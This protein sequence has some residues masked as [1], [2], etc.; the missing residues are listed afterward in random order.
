MPVDS[1]D[2]V[3]RAPGAT[4]GPL[5]V[6][7]LVASVVVHESVAAVDQPML[8]SAAAP[9]HRRSKVGAGGGLTFTTTESLAEPPGPVQVMVKV[10][11]PEVIFTLICDPE[12]GF[13]PEKK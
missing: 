5:P 9:L 7:Q 10:C 1:D 3:G 4:H 8:Q 13:E 6:V 2:A 12:V 11:G